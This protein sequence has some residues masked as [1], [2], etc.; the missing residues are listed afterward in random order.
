ML[1]NG[2][3]FAKEKSVGD[4]YVI[5]FEAGRIEELEQTQGCPVTCWAVIGYDKIAFALGAQIVIMQ[6][7]PNGKVTIVLESSKDEIHHGICMTNGEL[8]SINK[9]STVSRWNLATG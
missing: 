6:F 4:V 3:V 2:M 8:F 7:A 1:Q 9:N 5:D